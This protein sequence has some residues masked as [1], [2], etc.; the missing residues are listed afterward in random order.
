LKEWVGCEIE[1]EKKNRT[2]KREE[3]SRKGER[4]LNCIYSMVF[5]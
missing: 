5:L 2:E 4:E 3:R 1:K